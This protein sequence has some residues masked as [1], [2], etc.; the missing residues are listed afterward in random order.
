VP[1]LHCNYMADFRTSWAVALFLLGVSCS[2]DGDVISRTRPISDLDAGSVGSVIPDASAPDVGPT[3]TIIDL[4]DSGLSVSLSCDK[5]AL[6]VFGEPETVQCSAKDDQGAPISNVIWQVDDT[7]IGSIGDDGVFRA[8]GW[9]GGVV[10]VSAT[11]VGERASIQL[12]VEFARRENSG[13]ISA[14]DLDKLI[15]GG[16]G[17][18]NNIGPDAKLRWLYPYDQTVF[19]LGLPAPLLQLDGGSTSAPSCA[20]ASYLRLSTAHYTYELFSKGSSPLRIAIPEQVWKGAT[21]STRPENVLQASV[22][23]LC[24]GEVT[25]PVTESWRIAPGKMKGVVYYTRYVKDDRLNSGAMRLPLGSQAELLI[26]DCRVCHS[27]SA[28]G[29]VLASGIDWSGSVIDSATYDLRN[30]PPPETV[31]TPDGAMFSFAALTPDGKRALTWGTKS[32]SLGVRGQ[33]NGVTRLV[34]TTTAQVITT[35]SLSVQYAQ[36]PSFSPDGKHIAFNHTDV[37]VTHLAMMDYDGSQNPPVFSNVRDIAVHPTKALTWPS[38]LPDSLGVVYQ[39]SNKFETTWP[40]ELRLA[41]IASGQIK[42]LAALNGYAPDGSV[43]LPGGATGETSG[44]G[45]DWKNYEATVMPRPIGGYFWVMFSSRRSYGNTLGPQ[46]TVTS[47]QP[48]VRLKIWVAAIDIDHV[49][50]EDASHPAFYLPGQELDYGS[51]H[52]FVSL[53]PCR[54]L[55]ASCESGVD[56]CDGFCR[57]TGREPDG[58]PTLQCVPPPEGGCSLLDEICISKADCCNPNEECILGRC[59]YKLPTVE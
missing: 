8:N 4:G 17:G 37:G 58:T 24:G 31:K 46:G 39:E 22:S 44:Q 48:N 10:T 25:G 36:S 29:E 2:G 59:S 33:A 34:D 53:E 35:P 23:K 32:G 57:Q 55:G 1:A 52:P 5:A 21:L 3:E 19:P 12:T 40:S 28:N 14:G 49:G 18:P 56:C 15:A 51:L 47:T 54:P 9:A 20:D 42:R 43:Y 16:S 38:F 11:I 13:G 26:G 7:R 30:E 41:E 6:V 45:D 50:K 27:V